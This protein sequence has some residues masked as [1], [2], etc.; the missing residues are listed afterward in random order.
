MPEADSR[1][2][3]PV[4]SFRAGITFFARKIYAGSDMAH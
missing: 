3:R 4:K 1:M 2:P